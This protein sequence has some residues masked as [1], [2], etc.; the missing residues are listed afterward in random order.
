M[1]D[2]GPKV[3]SKRPASALMSADD[4]HE[5]RCLTGQRMLKPHWQPALNKAAAAIYAIGEPVARFPG[6]L[7]PM[8]TP[9]LLREYR[10]ACLAVMKLFDHLSWDDVVWRAPPPAYVHQPWRTLAYHLAVTHL[11]ARKA[12]VARAAQV[13]ER[14]INASCWRVER[15]RDDESVEAVLLAL[16]QEASIA[17][18]RLLGGEGSSGLSV[19]AYPAGDTPPWLAVLDEQMIAELAVK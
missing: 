11:G 19:P 16:E 5:R 18:L 8:G 13:S 17:M 15:D 2:A 12:D 1:T 10:A 9:P 4:W 14:A 6:I 3:R 7:S